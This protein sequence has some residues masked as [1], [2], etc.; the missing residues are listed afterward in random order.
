MIISDA[1]WDERYIYPIDL[2]SIDGEL[3][4]KYTV[5]P[6]EHLGYPPVN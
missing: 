3:V 6:M 5:R 4:G 1:P 2:A